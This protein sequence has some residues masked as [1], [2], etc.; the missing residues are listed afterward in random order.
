MTL[1]P[2]HAVITNP[3]KTVLAVHEAL[4]ELEQDGWDATRVRKRREL[5]NVIECLYFA[6]MTE[7]ETAEALKLAGG[8]VRPGG[9]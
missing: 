1:E 2:G 9:E 4:Q 3:P 7:E 8:E 5:A 6:G